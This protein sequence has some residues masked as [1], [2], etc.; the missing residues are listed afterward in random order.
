MIEVYPDDILYLNVLTKT[1]LKNGNIIEAQ[2]IFDDI[3]I[4]DDKN[5]A[6]IE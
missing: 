3:V 1:K 4:K 2:T 5:T 6:V